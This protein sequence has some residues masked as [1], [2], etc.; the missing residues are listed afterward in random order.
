MSHQKRLSEKVIA[1]AHTVMYELGAGFLEAVYEKALAVEMEEQGIGFVR[2]HPLDVCY[3]GRLVGTY[4]V[5]LIVENEL[6]L[7]LKAVAATNDKHKAQLLNYLRATGL[8]VSLLLNFGG[9]R[10]GIQRVVWNY[11]EAKNI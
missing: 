1:C 3:K 2:Q 8:N 9:S 5:D 10:L 4:Q 7:E 11:N 6:I